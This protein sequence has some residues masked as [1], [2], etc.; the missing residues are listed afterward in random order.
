LNLRQQR[1]LELLK[2]YTLDIKYHPR[3]ANVVA[4]A[5]SRKSKGMPASLLT[6]ETYPVRELEKLQ[7]EIIPPGEQIHLA[8]S[9]V[10]STIED[11]VKAGQPDDP[12]FVKI[13]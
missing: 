7:I 1:W 11:K 2:D 12:E 3:K 13:I 4:D 6:D 10:T 5:L 8:A 9:Q